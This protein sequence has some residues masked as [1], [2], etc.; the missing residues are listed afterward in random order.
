MTRT[1]LLWFIDRV[2]AL[3]DGEVDLGVHSAKDLPTDLPA[4]LEIA[5]VPERED[6]RDAYIGH[7]SSLGQVPEGARIGQRHDLRCGWG[8]GRG[9]TES[10]DARY[11]DPVSEHQNK[12]S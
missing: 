5:G 1:L 6:P 10:A 2:Q 3:L 9:N 4:G 8:Y 11:D 7:V 12:L